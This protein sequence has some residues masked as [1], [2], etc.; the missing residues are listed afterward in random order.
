MPSEKL[1]SAENLLKGNL[2]SAWNILEGSSGDY[3]D[4]GIARRFG[5]AASAYSLRDIGAMNGPVVNV[6]REPYDDDNPGKTDEQDFSANQVQSG[7]LEDWVNGK[8]ERTL[9]CNV[10]DNFVNGSFVVSDSNSSDINGTYTFNSSNSRWEHTSAIYFHLDS[11]T[12]TLVVDAASIAATTNGEYPWTSI[13]SLTPTNVSFGIQF[14]SI[15][16]STAAAAY[17]LRKVKAS[18]SGNAVRIRRSSDDVEVNVAFDSSDKVSS[19][20]SISIVSGSTT[21][22]TLGDFING[23]D[24]F[25]HTWYD[26]AGSNNLTQSTPANQPKIA[27]SGALIADG[28]DFDGSASYLDATSALGAT[29]NIGIFSVVTPD[30]GDALGYIIDN[31]DADDDGAALLQTDADS[32]R[33]L[34]S[35]DNFDVTTVNA[36]V[37]TSKTLVSG[38]QT[39][40]L[41]L[42]FKNAILAPIG[43]DN[44]ISVTSAFRV[45]ANRVS[46]GDYFDG[47]I[48]EIILYTSD[49]FDERFKIQS[50]INN[51]YNLYN[52]ENEMN[53]IFLQG[54]NAVVTPNGTNGFT[55]RGDKGAGVKTAVSGIQLKQ[56]APDNEI[57]YISFNA[58][59]GSATPTL[60]LR[61]NALGGPLS[62]DAPDSGEPAVVN[63][64]NTFAMVSSESDSEFVAFHDSTENEFTISDFRIARN[65]RDG[66]VETWYDQSN[67]GLNMTQSTAAD[68]PHIVEYGGIC[69]DPSGNNP[70][71]KFVNVGTNLGSTFLENSS[72]IS[73]P[74]AMTAF[75]V[76]SA[77]IVSGTRMT[78]SGGVADFAFDEPRLELRRGSTNLESTSTLSGDTNSILVYN[79]NSSF[80]TRYDINNSSETKSGITGTDGENSFEFLGE[81]SSSASND[82]FGLQGT[83]SEVILYTIDLGSEITDVKNEMNSFYQTF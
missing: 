78:F 72:P 63:G 71:V 47:R 54:G 10:G 27:S 8:L 17:S 80:L 38:I 79:N 23:T 53:G 65:P 69:K 66:Y 37:S 1:A 64:F 56:L 67:N 30:N 70:T 18:Y 9:P 2:A 16:Y 46:T 43:T 40:T 26:Q 52:D 62:S 55:G 68:Q 31:R 73:L 14:S 50:N 21:A 60:S 41:L 81:N 59:L 51:Y 36:S 48:E 24:A 3:T 34:F 49:E 4:L 74:T 44:P 76:A 35:M 22:T 58:T 33:Y 12:W 15:D 39:N 57:I 11:S 82:T 7:A 13:Y 75:F 61:R 45:G 5:G 20:S 32:G 6:R 77:T 83:M 19:S 28:L 42:L 25:V 29:S